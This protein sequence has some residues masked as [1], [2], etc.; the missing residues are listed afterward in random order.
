MITKSTIKDGGAIYVTYNWDTIADLYR[1]RRGLE[2]DEW[3][4]LRMSGTALAA[5]GAFFEWCVTNYAHL[6]EVNKLGITDGYWLVLLSPIVV[7]YWVAITTVLVS[8]ATIHLPLF[9]LALIWNL[10]F[11]LPADALNLS[12]IRKMENEFERKVIPEED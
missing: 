1:I 12:K 7:L 8:F 11:E 2:K 4:S 3:K 5:I 6:Y 10:C 9:I